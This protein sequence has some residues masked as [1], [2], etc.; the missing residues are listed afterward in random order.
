MKQLEI[1]KIDG[2]KEVIKDVLRWGF[3]GNFM[4]IDIEGDR[5]YLVRPL[6]EIKSYIAKGQPTVNKKKSK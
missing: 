2:S 6:S 1:E 3:N 5:L 4:I